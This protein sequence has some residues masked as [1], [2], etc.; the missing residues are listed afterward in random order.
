MDPTVKELAEST[1]KNSDALNSLT[2][3]FSGLINR[4]SKE[5]AAGTPSP[6]EVFGKG[7]P[8]ARN[9]ENSMGSRG[10]S[11]LKMLGLISGTVPKE[12]A[13]VEMDIAQRL[14][15][16]Y[17]KE[18]GTQGY[19]MK[20]VGNRLLA[21]LGTDLMHDP[22]VS[23]AF[24]Y[25]MKN[26]VAA[27]SP[28]SAWDPQERSWIANKML[29]TSSNP[30]MQQKALSWLSE[31]NGGALVPP[32]EFGE[33]IE[34]LRNKEAL[35]NAGAKTVPLPPQGRI[36]YPRQTSA[37][38]AYW[39]GEH[40]PIADSTPGT[41]TVTL[42]A[43]KLA[44]RII[45]P[46]EL[47]R[48][49]SPAAEALLR[50]DMTKTLALTMDLAGLQ[51]T[52]T[53]AQPRGVINLQYINS[54]TS[55]SPNPNG[56]SLTGKDIYRFIAAV[57]ESNAEFEAFIMRP[58]TLYKYYQL[59]ADAVGTGDQQGLFLFNAVRE[60]GDGVQ[61][62]LGGKKVITSTQVSQTR[63]KGSSTDL[64]YIVGGMWSDLLIGMF[65]AIEFAA[66]TQGDTA[67]ANDQTWVRGILSCDIAA[68]HDAAFV[69]MDQISPQLNP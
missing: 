54:I 35:V 28:A 47:L 37:S 66:A 10:F 30:V 12:Q 22:F 58:K 41:G 51:G 9:G 5:P 26:L 6:A 64:S 65:G 21:P 4:L 61:A 19:E 2:K 57:E 39:I 33:L 59:R 63:S 20:G 17:V 15:Q 14:H 44:V 50:D 38:T 42:S 18:A 40:A 48:F 68:R 62:M 23:Q 52:G 67:F 16:V 45:A 8:W 27:G 55:S 31:T 25:E 56:D 34:L 46:N 69:W 24:R 60:A 3:D 49:A 43:K 13:K 7:A 53:D 29:A 32:A 11:F 36:Q 1:R